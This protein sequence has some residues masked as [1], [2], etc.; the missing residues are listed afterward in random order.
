MTEQENEPISVGGKCGRKSVAKLINEVA[1]EY[2]E[3]TSKDMRR[4]IEEWEVD[5]NHEASATEIEME[6]LGILMR[7]PRH[8]QGQVTQFKQTLYL[9]WLMKS[10]LG[11]AMEKFR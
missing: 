11:K 4:L 7:D 10:L 8:T 3:G 9:Y 6:D 1:L 5:L 2:G